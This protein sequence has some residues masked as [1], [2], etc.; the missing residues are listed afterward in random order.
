[1][2][3]LNLAFPHDELYQED[4]SSTAQSRSIPV[5]HMRAYDSGDSSFKRWTNDYEPDRDGTGDRAPTPVGTFSDFIVERVI[6][7]VV[8][9]AIEEEM[10]WQW[11]GKDLS[12]FTLVY[13]NGV[14]GHG[15]AGDYTVTATTF[16]SDSAPALSIANNNSNS[17]FLIYVINDLQVAV[18][19]RMQLCFRHLVVT[20]GAMDTGLITYYEN[21]T[22]WAA[23][24]RG[25]SVAMHVELYD[26]ATGEVVNTIGEVADAV[27]NRNTT[28]GDCFSATVL[29]SF[30]SGSV[31]PW[32][33]AKAGGELQAGYG[34]AGRVWR[35][36]HTITQASTNADWL[37]I[38]T[39]SPQIG[40]LIKG[41]G[42]AG[43]DYMGGMCF[44]EAYG[45]V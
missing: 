8:S 15:T 36:T 19:T 14:G 20:P 39:Y 25:S 34:E 31:K 27:G 38:G 21:N 45:G 7:R 37:S 3:T 1:M 13:G 30:A 32:I 43:T 16:P 26:G 23:I 18:P 42:T 17:N 9:T 40:L 35:K 5:Y 22:H 41:A 11:N 28:Y 4:R 6:E 2:A 12:Q 24:R 33:V 29:Q 44:R 10:F